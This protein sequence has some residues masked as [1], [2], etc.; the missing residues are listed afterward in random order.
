[1]SA[2]GTQGSRHW[3]I[4]KRDG[5]RLE[6]ANLDVLRHWVETGQ[7]GPDDKVIHDDLA[8]WILAAEAVELDDLFKKK[9]RAPKKESPPPATSHIEPKVEEEEIKVPDCAFHP[10]RT[11]SEICVGCGKFICEECRQ[12][13]DRKIYCKRCMA[14]K[15]VGVEPGA[16]VGV[17]AISAIG[18]GTDRP[19]KVSGFA[20][21]SISLAVL[22]LLA[23]APMVYPTPNIFLALPIGFVAFMAA[24]LG[25]LAFSRIRRNTNPLRGEALALSGLMVGIVTIAATLVVALTL[26][27]DESATGSTR[28]TNTSLPTAPARRVFNSS[29]GDKEKREAAAQRLLDRAGHLLSEEKLAPAIEQCNQIVLLYPDTQAAKLVEERLPLLLAESERQKAESE[30]IKRRNEEVAQQSYEQ[31]KSL[32]SGGDRDLGVELLRNLVADFPETSAAKMALALIEEEDKKTEE[33]R[34]RKEEEEARELFARANHLLETEQY[35]DAAQLFRRITQEYAKTSVFSDATLRLEEAM[36]LVSDPAEREFH[37]VQKEIQNLTY[38]ESIDRIQEFLGKYPAGNRVVEAGELLN[39]NA[40]QKRTAD[41][42]Y[43]FGRGYFEDGKYEVAVGRFTKLLQD[44]PRSRWAA[45]ARKEYEECIR[46]M[47]E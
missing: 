39:E 15:Q 21:A 25:G 20:I 31:A 40:Q 45:Q 41:N 37:K 32:Y 10:G 16:P 30:A 26:N 5:S 2:E 24:L 36:A 17:S 46:R 29:R 13:S 7:I 38:D 14:E 18:G 4:K 6:P 34:L 33:E 11:A 1:M 22:G 43:N 35:A 3:K 44:Y 23:C 42:L 19:P 9:G 47:E 12:R 8:D 27:R 28:S